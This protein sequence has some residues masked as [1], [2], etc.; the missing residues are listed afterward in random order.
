MNIAPHSSQE[1]PPPK[2]RIAGSPLAL[3][4]R[5]YAENWFLVWLA[6]IL[7]AGMAKPEAFTPFLSQDIQT[8]G[9][10][11]VVFFVMFMMSLA[12][13]T[14]ALFRT[15][16]RPWSSIL[17]VLLNWGLIP[18]LAMVAAPLLHSEF[19]PGL[20]LAAAMP[21]S[22]A[23]A[24]VW[25]RRAGGNDA[26]A[27]LV[28]VI[29]NGTC[30][31]VTPLL[32]LLLTGKQVNFNV[33]DKVTELAIVVLLPLVLGQVIRQ[34]DPIRA[35]CDRHRAILGVVTQ[36]GLL[37]VI[38]LGAVKTGERLQQATALSPSLLNTLLM[39]GIVLA[40][41]TAVLLIGYLLARSL[42]IERPDRI[43][44]AIAGSQKTLMIGL[45]MA[46]ELNVSILPLVTFHAGQLLIDAI[47]AE[48][49]RKTDSRRD[50]RPL[51]AQAPTQ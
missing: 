36:S 29:T 45:S 38:L 32:V 31:A 10:Q 34:I 14:D 41:H 16:K 47:F 5:F 50:V 24:S 9:Q 11:G 27:L 48:R 12:L 18:L 8:R 2:G 4:A 33:Q 3:F 23:S 7:L 40:V 25:T 22:M 21:C 30:F 19:R 6:L 46:V 37:F 39:I 44:V 15:V 49:L 35:W 17:G 20:F 43:A 28:T 51:A 26:I 42:R 13:P 1:R